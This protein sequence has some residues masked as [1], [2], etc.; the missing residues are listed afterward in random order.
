MGNL[1]NHPNGGHTVLDTLR[2]PLGV[3]CLLTAL[4]TLGMYY[5]NVADP[6]AAIPIWYVVDIFV[7]L[8]IFLTVVVNIVDSLRIRSDPSAHLRQLPRDIITVIAALVLMV[9]LQTTCSSPWSP[10]PKTSGCGCTCTPPPSRF[11][12]GRASR[13]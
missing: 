9:F 3:L 2:K 13:W 7:C 4:V 10:G 1:L 5:Y 11:S 6:V 8:G 12:P